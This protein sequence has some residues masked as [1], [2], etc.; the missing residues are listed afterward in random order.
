M[1]LYN[2]FDLFFKVAKISQ[3]DILQVKNLYFN[4]INSAKHN[5]GSK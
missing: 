4:R 5:P 3:R 1:F 2:N